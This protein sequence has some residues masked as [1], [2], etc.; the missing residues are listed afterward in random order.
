MSDKK[1]PPALFFRASRMNLGSI[2]RLLFF[3]ALAIA[4]TAWAIV[5]HR[6]R[7]EPPMI[8]PAAAPTYD[9]DAGELPVPELTAP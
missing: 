5:R 4:G 3:A 1:R 7:V 9:A 6:T 8:V 2:L